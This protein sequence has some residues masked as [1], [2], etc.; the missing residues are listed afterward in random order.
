MSAEVGERDEAG[1]TGGPWRESQQ[2]ARQMAV[3]SRLQPSEG[4][5]ENRGKICLGAAET[6]WWV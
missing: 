1:A 3:D 4:A 6:R 5:D 2:E